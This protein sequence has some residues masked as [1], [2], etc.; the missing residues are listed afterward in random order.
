MTNIDPRLTLDENAT[1]I[2]QLPAPG[3]QR[4]IARR[5]ADVVAAVK[6]GV[7]TIEEACARYSLSV[8]EFLSWQRDFSSHGISGLRSTRVQFYR[9]HPA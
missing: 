5:K 3:T 6:V 7:L 9:R 1:P 2:A 8:E 4:W